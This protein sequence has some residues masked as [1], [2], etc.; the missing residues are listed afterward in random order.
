MIDVK[1]SKHYYSRYYCSLFISLPLSLYAYVSTHNRNIFLTTQ[2]FF[3]IIS[4]RGARM[5]IRET[6][7]GCEILAGVRKAGA[8]PLFHVSR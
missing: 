7:D 4:Q 5:R 3:Q 8:Q 6:R 2:N 1:R